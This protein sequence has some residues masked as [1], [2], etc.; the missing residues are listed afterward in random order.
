MKTHRCFVTKGETMTLHGTVMHGTIVLDQPA[1]WP[2]GA[3]VEV[4]L[5]EQP[6]AEQEKK[7]TLAGLLKLAGSL[8]DLPPDFAAEHDHYLHGTPKRNQ[9]GA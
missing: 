3:R 6:T 7:P 1:P 4:T 9:R 8:S 5:K 2:E